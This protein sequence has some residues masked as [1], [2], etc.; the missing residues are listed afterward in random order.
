MG[1]RFGH[2]V[3]VGMQ[4][5][6][7]AA[8]AVLVFGLIAL[9]L[10]I[11]AAMVHG[12]TAVAADCSS[13]AEPGIDWSG[14]RKR[15][16]VLQGSNLIGANMAE[17]DLALT[18]LS[19]TNLTQAN[20]EKATLLRAW[21]TDAVLTKA[22]FNRV[23]GYRAGFERASAQGA[24]F[25]SAE[26]QRANFRS[27]VLTGAD[28]EKAELGRADFSGAELT[29]VR[30]PYANLSRADLSKAR[31]EGALDFTHAFLFLT[32]LEGLDL[33]T[34]I[35]LEQEQVDLACGDATTKL[36]PGFTTPSKWPCPFD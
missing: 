33:S 30:F 1:I 36:P 34:S 9:A 23:E 4:R 27:A 6:R 7:A 26:L 17:S 19:Q 35:G 10:S 24:T 20:L 5:A 2:R 18:D 22:N 13:S 21:F 31:F 15:M 12:R 32:R 3:R 14:C 16:I 29:G 25:A 28:F 8:G 11:G